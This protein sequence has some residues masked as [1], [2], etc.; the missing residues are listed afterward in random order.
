MRSALTNC[1]MFVRTMN[2]CENSVDRLSEPGGPPT[3]AC[4]TS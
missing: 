4:K 1:E 2:G 3:E